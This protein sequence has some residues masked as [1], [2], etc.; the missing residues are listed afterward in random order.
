LRKIKPFT[1]PYRDYEIRITHIRRENSSEGLGKATYHFKM[2]V[3]NKAK[4]IHYTTQK[5]HITADNVEDFKYNLEMEIA[6]GMK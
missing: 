2:I 6:M 4:G 1:I 5:R 3:K